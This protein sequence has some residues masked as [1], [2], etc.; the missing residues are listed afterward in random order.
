MFAQSGMDPS[1]PGSSLEITGQVRAAEGHKTAE[2]V[3]V[4]L[5]RASGGLVDQR[6]ARVDFGF[7]D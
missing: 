6:T 2:F 3:T 5:E 1:L 7:R 4:R